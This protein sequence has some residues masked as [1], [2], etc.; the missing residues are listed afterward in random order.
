[1]HCSVFTNSVKRVYNS[2][3]DYH[4][5]QKLMGY[6]E[7]QLDPLKKNG[8]QVIRLFFKLSKNVHFGHRNV[9]VNRDGPTKGQR[10][11]AVD[12]ATIEERE[13]LRRNT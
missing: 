11:D 1:M 12:K 3:K 13:E 7:V 5:T 9:Q 2:I 10:T 4:Q 6:A 8:R